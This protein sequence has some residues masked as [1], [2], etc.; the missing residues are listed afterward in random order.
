VAVA[1]NQLRRAIFGV[2]GAV[3]WQFGDLAAFLQKTETH[4]RVGQAQGEEIGRVG[5]VV[6]ATG[7]NQGGT[8]R[9][10]QGLMGS[11]EWVAFSDAPIEVGAQASV[12]AVEGNTLRITRI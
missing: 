12:V 8:I 6:V 5:E 3:T 2:C 1:R 7:P 9:F 11:R 10:A 4:H